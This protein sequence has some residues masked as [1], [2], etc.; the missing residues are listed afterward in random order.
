MKQDALYLSDSAY[1]RP[2]ANVTFP[3]TVL[4]CI[5]AILYLDING[6]LPS[7][8]SGFRKNHSMET[9]LDRLLS[10]LYG[11]MDVAQ[12]SLLALFF[13]VSSAFDS[14]GHCILL[15]TLSAFLG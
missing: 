1:C 8:Q 14:L 13:D 2:I 10:D 9:L 7:H 12:I 3:S 4:G 5:V 6:L 11:A 15:Q